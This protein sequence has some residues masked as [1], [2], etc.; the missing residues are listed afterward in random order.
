MNTLARPYDAEEITYLRKVTLPFLRFHA[1]TILNPSVSAMAS[2]N[3]DIFE[4]FLAT[5][6]AKDAEILALSQAI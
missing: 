1:V 5:I 6:D 3:A 4:R 2:I